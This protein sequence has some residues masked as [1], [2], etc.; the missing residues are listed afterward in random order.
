METAK[1]TG[2]ERRN[3]LLKRVVI[4]RQHTA[5]PFRDLWAWDFMTSGIEQ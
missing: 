1:Q 3:G 2:L 4:Q 5:R